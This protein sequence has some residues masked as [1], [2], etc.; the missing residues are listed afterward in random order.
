MRRLERSSLRRESKSIAVLM[1][2][3][4]LAHSRYGIYMYPLMMSNDK[5]PAISSPVNMFQY[6]TGFAYLNGFWKE[7]VRAG[8]YVMCT[9]VFSPLS[10]RATIL[11]MR[12]D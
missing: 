4:R 9:T 6:T 1:A 12:I 8:F 10:Y 5:F 11:I 2:A 7:Y 3:G